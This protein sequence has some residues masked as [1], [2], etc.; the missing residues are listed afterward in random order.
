MVNQSSSK[1]LNSSGCSI[2]AA[3]IIDQYKVELGNNLNSSATSGGVTSFFPNNTGLHIFWQIFC[4]IM[5]NGT[6]GN[7]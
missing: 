5:T 1:R 6:F 7:C 4:H 3:Y 2:I